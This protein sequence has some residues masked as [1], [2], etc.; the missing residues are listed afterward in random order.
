[1]ST[2]EEAK[3]LKSQYLSIFGFIYRSLLAERYMGQGFQGYLRRCLLAHETLKEKG[4]QFA[5]VLISE[6]L[7]ILGDHPLAEATEQPAQ[8]QAAYWQ[9][10]RSEWI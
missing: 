2:F 8:R 4:C 10:S 1:M 3:M 7:G 5:K 9:T 6:C